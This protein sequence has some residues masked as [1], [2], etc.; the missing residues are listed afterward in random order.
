MH[1]ST[2]AT[3]KF[4]V[5]PTLP[6]TVY[7]HYT[8]FKSVLLCYKQEGAAYIPDVEVR[9]EKFYGSS[10]TTDNLNLLI[11][12]TDRTGYVCRMYEFSSPSSYYLDNIVSLIVGVTFPD[13]AGYMRIYSTTFVLGP[14]LAGPG[15]IYD[16]NLRLIMH[17]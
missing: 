8:F 1:S 4:Q 16:V 12:T 5:T 17:H 7:G 3:Q 10:G 14:S 11:D 2:V 15:Y 6:S 9:H 13:I